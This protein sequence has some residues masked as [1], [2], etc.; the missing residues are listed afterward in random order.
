MTG[1]WSILIDTIFTR[2]DATLE[3][4]LDLVIR[5]ESDTNSTTMNVAQ[6]IDVWARNC[7]TAPQKATPEMFV[8][9]PVPTATSTTATIQNTKAP[10]LIPVTAVGCDG[11]LFSG[12]PLAP[13]SYGT[14]QC[15]QQQQQPVAY[16]TAAMPPPPYATGNAENVEIQQNSEKLTAAATRATRQ[17]KRRAKQQ[18][19][20]VRRKSTPQQ[21]EPS[22]GAM[23]Y[24]LKMEPDEYA[25]TATGD[26]NNGTDDESKGDGKSKKGRRAVRGDARAVCVFVASIP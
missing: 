25:T 9:P 22:P 19:T 13:Q 24:D 12:R 6:C 11:P 26:A 14:Q 4:V 21:G 3:D 8:Q 5:G 20:S 16:A 1:A 10:T 17:H 23:L 15:W 18:L 7:N 2:R